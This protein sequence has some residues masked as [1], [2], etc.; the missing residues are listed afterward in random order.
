MHTI[1][2]YLYQHLIKPVLFLFPADHVH[3][4]FLWK[5]RM[6]GKIG[7]VRRVVAGLW[8]FD[9]PILHEE[10]L[11]LHF[12]NPIGLS[13]GFDYNADLV[14]ILPDI[15][16]GFHTIGTLTLGAYQ[17]NPPPMLGRLPKSRSLIV[18][19]GFKNKGVSAVLGG[20]SA[21]D[22]RAVRG[23]SVGATNRAYE[24]FAAMVDDLVEGF[25]AA[26]KCS[27]FDYYELNI[28]CP[29]L[30]NLQNLKMQLASPDGLRLA[31]TTLTPLD[32]TR[33]VFIKM[34]LERSDEETKQ[35]IETVAPFA[36]VRG[37][38]FSNLAKDRSNPAF[39]SEEIAKAGKG[40]FSGKPVEARSNELLRYAY[41]HYGDRYVLI[42]V[43]GVFTAADAYEKIRSGASLV[44]LI[45]GMIF[46]GPQQIGLINKELAELLRR[47]GYRSVSEAVG[48]VAR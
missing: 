15:G 48:S 26:E 1:S 24:D 3:E 38:I 31:L 42:G 35:L 41:K 32:L 39:D 20:I 2:G 19:K 9:D 30:L 45:T 10:L 40:N 37:F 4:L 47:D 6:L 8:R 17:G 18:N 29:N 33:P 44:Q 25:R 21:S 23:V 27:A 12:T 13:A 14:D 16:F 28:S 43:G 22:G 7:S 36:F 34:P 5:G 46:M 11:G